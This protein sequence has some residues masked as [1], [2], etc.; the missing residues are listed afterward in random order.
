M[1]E[2][3]GRGMQL[4][5]ISGD[6]GKLPEVKKHVAKGSGDFG[7]VQMCECG[8]SGGFLQFVEK[9]KYLRWFSTSF[10]CCLTP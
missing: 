4:V 1:T 7:S 9:V 6:Y 5:R 10:N 3:V 8:G 2:A